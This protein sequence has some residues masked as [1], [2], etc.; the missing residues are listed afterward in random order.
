MKF[1]PG[2]R[3]VW[4]SS[5]DE[6]TVAGIT[7]KWRIWVK[8]DNGVEMHHTERMLKMVP[9]RLISRQGSWDKE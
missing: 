9:R 7:G 1:R 2:D 3:V 4:W 6:G 8:W 5:E